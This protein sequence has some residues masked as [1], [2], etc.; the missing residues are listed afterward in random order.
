MPSVAV[1]GAGQCARHASPHARA[2][3]PR[4]KS[5]RSVW[6][7]NGSFD[8]DSALRAVN[9]LA[10]IAASVFVTAQESDYSHFKTN[11][12]ENNIEVFKL[13]GRT[14]NAPKHKKIVKSPPKYGNSA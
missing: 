10:I 4:Q 12:E 13:P 11:D 1:H 14:R 6:V 5:A 3:T 9:S 8:V 2:V 7:G